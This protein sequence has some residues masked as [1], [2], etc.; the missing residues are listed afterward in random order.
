MIKKIKPC[1]LCGGRWQIF[2]IPSYKTPWDL[3]SG[4]WHGQCKKC[5]VT[6]MRTRKYNLIKALNRRPKNE[7]ISRNKKV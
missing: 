2:N 7:Y 5:G 6:I 1:P 3:E 4:N